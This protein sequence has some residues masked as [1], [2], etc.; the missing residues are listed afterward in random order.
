MVSFS[1]QYLE[2]SSLHMENMTIFTSLLDLHLGT[3][4]FDHM[5]FEH[6]GVWK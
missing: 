4:W 2:S 5:I 1:Q 3:S 6:T